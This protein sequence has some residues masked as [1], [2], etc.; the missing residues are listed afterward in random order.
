MPVQIAL[1]RDRDFRHLMRTGLIHTAERKNAFLPP[2]AALHLHLC[3]IREGVN[4]AL[5]YIQLVAVLPGDEKTEPL[6][7]A[8]HI[9][10]KA[11]V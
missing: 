8:R 1:Q 4:G 10:L 3:Q 6:I 5:E 7:A 11:A 9:S 2:V